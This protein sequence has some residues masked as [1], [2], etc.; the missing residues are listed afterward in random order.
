M[1]HWT[2]SEDVIRSVFKQYS[3][4]FIMA[5][6]VANKAMW[7]TVFINI[8]LHVSDLEVGQSQS[9]SLYK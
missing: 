1:Q 4:L 7:Q 3:N 2:L 5:G 8:A 6:N 9:S